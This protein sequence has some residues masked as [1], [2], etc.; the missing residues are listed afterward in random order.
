MTQPYKLKQTLTG[1]KR[2]ISSAI[3]FHDGK[4]I[5][6]ST[7]DKTATPGPPPMD[8]LS[9]NSWATNKESQTSHSPPTLATSQPLPMTKPSAFGTY[10]RLTRQNSNRRHEP[11]PLCR[12]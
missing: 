8:L 12:T 3:F 2:S 7:A 11:R 10:P 5:A 1:N 4:L 6:T 9:K